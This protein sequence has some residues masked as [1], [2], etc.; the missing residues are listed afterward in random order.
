MTIETSP[1]PS[2]P[3][4]E[5][6]ARSRYFWERL[7]SGKSPD[8]ADLA[9]LRV[10]VGREAGSVPSMW[11]HYT[12][13]TADGRLS[14]RL[15]AEHVALTLYA[16]HQ[17]SQPTSV[18]RTGIGL[19][20]AVHALRASEK[21]SPDAVDRRFNAVAT[22]TSLDECAHHLRGLVRQLRL[23]SQGLDYTALVADLDGW[24][25]PARIG[26][27]RR[28]WGRQYFLGRDRADTERSP[29]AGR[30]AG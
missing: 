17:Q 5:P 28:D 22:A 4:Q 25:H 8:G 18:H 26:R 19:G 2:G 15:R 21:F 24:Q 30:P 6:W 29:K 12:M 16:I 7:P 11:R 27:V 3:A 20:K 13:L 23:I 10:G 14:T 9:A 1:T